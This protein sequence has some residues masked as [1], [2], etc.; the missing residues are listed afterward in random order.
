MGVWHSLRKLKWPYVRAN[1]P[2]DYD[3]APDHPISRAKRE[4]RKLWFQ[5]YDEGGDPAAVL[6]EEARQLP[7]D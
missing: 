7:D 4:F 5:L 2:C 6:T 1:L 3:D